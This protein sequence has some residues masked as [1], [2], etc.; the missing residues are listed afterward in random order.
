MEG[1]GD[2]PLTSGLAA[3]DER[4]FSA[5]YDQFGDRLYR[6]ALAMLGSRQDAEDTVQEVFVA[7]L[8]SRRR[9][10]GV[11]DFTAYLFTAL[12]RAAGRCAARRARAPALSD[13]A[14]NQA[15]AEP[16]LRD[17][18]S[19]FAERLDRAMSA[20]PVEQREVI[21][22]RIDGELSF[23]Q[24]AEIMG[25]NINTAASRYRYALEKLRNSLGAGR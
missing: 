5:L 25:V 8:Q 24:I 12:R 13:G 16:A 3:G 2:D 17:E 7:I 15:T 9:L 14:V 6:A 19:Q 21:A 4:A 18:R 11:R 22:L 20:L 10:A 23:A 1:C